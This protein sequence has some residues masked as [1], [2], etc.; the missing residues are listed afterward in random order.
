M[1]VTRPIDGPPGGSNTLTDVSYL[2]A[3]VIAGGSVMCGGHWEHE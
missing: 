2:I 1:K 3:R